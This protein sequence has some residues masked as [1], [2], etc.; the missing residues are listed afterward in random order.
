MC[1]FF[2]FHFPSKSF[3]LS[4][5]KILVHRLVC[6]HRQSEKHHLGTQ[7]RQTS[8]TEEA[9]L[10]FATKIQAKGMC[11]THQASKHLHQYLNVVLVA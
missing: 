11:I 5:T 9:M 10:C 1:P 6:E 3:L 2:S 7:E 4:F 8:T